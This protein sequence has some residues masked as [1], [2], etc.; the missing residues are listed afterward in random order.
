MKTTENDNNA[1]RRATAASSQGGGKPWMKKESARERA[2][3]AK[4][5]RPRAKK[6]GQNIL[7]VGKAVASASAG[8][9]AVSEVGRTKTTTAN[10]IN[11]NDINTT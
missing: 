9:G 4:A 6:E 10:A 7:G 5:R 3:V 2:R 1:Y 11:E 8:L